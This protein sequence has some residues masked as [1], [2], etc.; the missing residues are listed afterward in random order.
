MNNGSLGSRVI[1]F[2]VGAMVGA[3]V[4]NSLN[5]NDD[6]PSAV[7]AAA[8]GEIEG[9]A[10]PASSDAKV[11]SNPINE[12][13][14]GEVPSADVDLP[15]NNNQTGIGMPSIYLDMFG[16][17]IVRVTHH[18]LH[19]TFMQEPR[20]DAW[21]FDVENAIAQKAVDL[22]VA[23]WAVVEH[24]ECRSTTC[25]IAGYYTVDRDNRPPMHLV[26]NI[27]KAIWFHDNMASNTYN[28]N[29]D[30]FDRFFTIVTA[31]SIPVRTR[32]P[33]PLD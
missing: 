5:R 33:H 8:S 24:I 23:K 26:Q 11:A 7:A 16:P 32:E 30:G 4:V 25:E 31:R 2:L 3:V 15:Q 14:E 10:T 22:E 21:A 13:P 12:K 17:P 9:T 18:D 1:T 27:D 20:H 28:A 29:P 6:R 19:A